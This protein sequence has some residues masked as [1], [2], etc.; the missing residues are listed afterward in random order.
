MSETPNV[1]IDEYGFDSKSVDDLM[2]IVTDIVTD[3]IEL[4]K[5][6][7]AYVSGVND[8]LKDN[9]KRMEAAIDQIR[10]KKAFDN[11]EQVDKLA[12]KLMNSFPIK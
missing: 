8:V 1:K 9:K 10:I 2:K 4:Q 3:S 7:K 11:Q 12:D 6:K 5:N